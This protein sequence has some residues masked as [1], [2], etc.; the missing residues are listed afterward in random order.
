MNALR[1]SK[2]GDAAGRLY[3]RLLKVA[4]FLA[5]LLLRAALALPFLRS[6]LTRWDGF[7]SLSAGQIYLFEEQFKLHLFGHECAL[8]FP[9]ATAYLVGVLEILLPALLFLGCATRVA[10]AGLLAMTCVIQLVAPAGWANFHLYWAAISTA[11]IAFGPGILSLDR[12][13][14]HSLEDHGE[15]IDEDIAYSWNREHGRGD[16]PG[17]D[18]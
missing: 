2:L 1:A 5:P 3:A 6:G 18:Q 7:L 16:R 17:R 13:I 10:A 14:G 12:L 15:I 11:L 9:D 8:P 4:A